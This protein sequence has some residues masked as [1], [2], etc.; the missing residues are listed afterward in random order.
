MKIDLHMHST[1][2]DGV[3]TP[4]E[5]ID[6]AVKQNLAAI[7]LTDHDCLDGI[8][9]AMEAGD[10]NNVEVIP[11]VELSAEYNGRDLHILGYGVDP[12]DN[13]FQDMLKKFR[14]KR[15][16]RGIKIIE[17]LNAQGVNIDPADVLAKSGEGAL[18]RPH[19]AAVLLEKGVVSRTGEA[20]DK[21]IGEGGPAYVEKYKMS[22]SEAIGYIHS[23]G[24]VAFT[25][26]P[27]VFL[28]SM[29][30][31]NKLLAEGFDGIEVY[32]PSHSADTVRKLEAVA[33]KHSLLV[34][35]GSDFHGF[36][37]RD[38]PMGVLDISYDL[39]AKIKQKLNSR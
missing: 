13:V 32:H 8:N 10:E 20:F 25:A 33:E 34:S 11:G 39:L 30:D 27:G 4:R 16:K 14:E 24:G 3:H 23:A 2:S 9:E 15:H 19:I 21:Y 29:D 26:H 31:M 18:G 28:E 6:M 7:S 22:A 5:L 12:A 1:F 35:G 38:M 36:T 37:G 17:L